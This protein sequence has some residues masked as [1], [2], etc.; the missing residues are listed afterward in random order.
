[1]KVEIITIGDEILIGQIVDTNSA[2]MSKEL[3]IAGFE[4][5]QITSIHDDELQI[6]ETVSKALNR[7][8]IILITGGIGPTNDDITK[9]TLSKLFNSKLIFDNQTYARIEKML[10]H[11]KQALNELTKSQAMVPDKAVVIPNL[12]GTAPITWFN[13]AD[14][15]VVVS[16]PGVPFE[17]KK[18]MSEEI[19]PRLKDK[20]KLDTIIHKTVIV[21]GYPESALALK[22][23]E[24][25]NKLP[26]T[27]KLAYL[28]QF[29]IVK[30]R[31]SAVD[32]G[33]DALE[34][35]IDDQINKLRHI[36]GDAIISLNDKPL[37]EL[38]G[39]ILTSKSQSLSI[40]ESCTG[41]DV[42]RKITSVPGSS[43]YYKGSVVAYDNS[44]KTNLLK[45][46]DVDLQNYGAVSETV[47][48]QMANRVM[49]LLD[50]DY[51]IA[52]S[53]IAGPGGGT[54]EKPVGTVWIAVSSKSHCVT[55]EFKFR[56]ERNVN[57][58]RATQAALMMLYE[59]IR[60]K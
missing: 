59:I 34:T 37:E 17:M 18:V 54:T 4:V 5:E 48:Q 35:E 14:N 6:T 45:V 39:D 41:G 23:A 13:V 30:L 9:Q 38:I 51:S 36:L 42:S 46:K 57:I 58:E 55:K 47:V 11:R 8:D 33:N 16:M 26:R 56:N 15:K 10:E 44:V 43:M 27:I 29:G 12:V 52:T 19:I 24:W 31:L 60:D 20:Y 50:T 28:P 32:K 40:A 3:N 53:G 2:W 7:A 22:I 21:S 49:H 25:E 1:M